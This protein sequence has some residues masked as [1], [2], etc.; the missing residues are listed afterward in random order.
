[1]KNWTGRIVSVLAVL[2]L[3][4]YAGYQGY[5]YMY[6]PYRTETAYEYTVSDTLQTKGLIVRDE[7]LI[8]GSTEG[9]PSYCVNE[10]EKVKK[11]TEIIRYYDNAQQARNAAHAEQLDH[12]IELLTKAQDPG[13]YMFANSESLSGQI[14]ELIGQMVDETALNDASGIQEIRTHLLENLC[15]RQLSV[16]EA[17]DFNERI[18]HLQA[19]RDSFSNNVAENNGSLYAPKQGYFSRY[20]DGCEAQFSSKILFDMTADDLSAAIARDYLLSHN[21]PGK[22]MTEHTWYCAMVLPEEDGER[23]REGRKVEVNF[24][25]EAI[26]GVVME[27]F[28]VEK[29]DSGRTIVILSSK[30][31][32]PGILSA[33]SVSVSVHFS[34]Y[35]GLRVSDSAVRLIDGQIGVYISTGYEVRFRPIDVLYQGDGY[36]I[37]RE[38]ITAENGLKMFDQ[39]IVKGTDLYDGKPLL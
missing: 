20:S 21:S 33:R 1:M 35:K 16:D 39:V 23:F 8:E 38:D 3:L 13:S 18:S 28:R 14:D 26:S 10:G 19:Q 22:I 30:E 4:I 32:I 29:D 5:R 25:T 24:D 7:I 9:S 12:E 34:T 17:E 36:Q 31:I 6:T 27:V 11:G 37:C 2:F 15:K